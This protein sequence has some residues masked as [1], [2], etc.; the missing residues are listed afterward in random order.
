MRATIFLSARHRAD[1]RKRLI[2]KAIG[3]LRRR[4]L[5]CFWFR[6]RLARRLMSFRFWR[7]NG[8]KFRIIKSKL[9]EQDAKNFRASLRRFTFTI[10]Y[11]DKTFWRKPSRRRLNFRTQNIV[12]E[13]SNNPPRKTHGGKPVSNPGGANSPLPSPGVPDPARNLYRQAKWTQLNVQFYALFFW[14]P[15]S[16]F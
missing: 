3:N 6:S 16:S 13:A 11:M 9:S 7:K 1:T 15:Q 14:L 10:W 4:R 5:N 12:R 8:K 2:R